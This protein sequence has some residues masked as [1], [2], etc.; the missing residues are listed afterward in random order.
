[1]SA[2]SRVCHARLQD[3]RAGGTPI[4]GFRILSDANEMLGF[5]R[6]I[7]REVYDSPQGAD[8]YVGFQTAGKM[9][10]EGRSYRRLARAGVRVA[11]FGQCPLEDAPEGLEA[12]PGS[13]IPP[14]RES[15]RGWLLAS[16]TLYFSLQFP[17]ALFG[18]NAG[19]IR[20][21]KC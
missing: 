19:V 12:S 17:D 18:R 9:A 11:A 13:P 2:E 4:E 10:G 8:L 15:L 6:Q 5:S 20:L 14:R 1:M 21:I 3:T 7:E 16:K